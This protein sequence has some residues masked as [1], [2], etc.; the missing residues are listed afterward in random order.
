MI[1]SLDSSGWFI[2]MKIILAIIDP[3][4]ETVLGMVQVPAV[5]TPK[6]TSLKTVSE[7][8]KFM[9]QSF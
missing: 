3:K 4:T 1:S 6:W 7:L 5:F 8:L 9:L 2:Q